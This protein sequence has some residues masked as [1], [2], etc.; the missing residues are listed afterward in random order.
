MLS[1]EWRT[2]GERTRLLVRLI[3]TLWITD[4][5][6]EIILLLDNEV[7]DATKVCPLGV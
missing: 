3:G 7:S 6:Q 5:G 4:L 2:I 1:T